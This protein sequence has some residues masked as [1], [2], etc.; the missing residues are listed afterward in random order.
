[1]RVHADPALER[2]AGPE[3][4]PTVAE[5]VSEPGP[6]ADEDVVRWSVARELGL[7]H[8]AIACRIVR[9]PVFP[10]GGERIRVAVKDTWND[11]HCAVG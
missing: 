1:L 3:E 10:N 11:G 8:H 2:G 6:C 5:L 7:R 9:A 4:G